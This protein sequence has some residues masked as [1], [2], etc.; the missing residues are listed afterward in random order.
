M[1]YL[2]KHCQ[3]FHAEMI[4]FSLVYLRKLRSAVGRVGPSPESQTS[5]LSPCSLL[6]ESTGFQFS[7]SHPWESRSQ[8]YSRARAASQP[9][10]SYLKGTKGSDAHSSSWDGNSPSNDSL[11]GT[12]ERLLEK[13]LSTPDY[14]SILFIE[15]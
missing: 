5:Q 13:S 10:F 4:S 14:F 3:L 15:A 7:A 12:G 9:F 2:Q 8:D 11:V 6:S 1:D